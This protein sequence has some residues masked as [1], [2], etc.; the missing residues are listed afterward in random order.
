MNAR[1]VA[2]F[3]IGAYAGG[4]AMGSAHE[5]NDL[6]GVLAVS[7]LTFGAGVLASFY[8]LTR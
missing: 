3:A 5:N 2:W 6:A 1:A 7:G 4:K 8:L